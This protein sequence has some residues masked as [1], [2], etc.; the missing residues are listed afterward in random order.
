[1]SIRKNALLLELVGLAVVGALAGLLLGAV[2]GSGQM[3]VFVVMGVLG[4]P[5]L[6]KMACWTW[7]SSFFEGLFKLAAILGT[8]GLL[9]LVVLIDDLV[10]KHVVAPLYRGE[11]PLRLT[12]LKLDA[13]Q[14]SQNEPEMAAIP[15]AMISAV[16]PANATD[17][18]PPTTDDLRLHALL[19]QLASADWK[20]A[21]TAAIDLGELGDVRAAEPLIGCLSHD[22]PDV[23]WGAAAALAKLGDQLKGTEQA[24]SAASKLL[25]LLADPH[26]QLRASAADALG[27]LGATETLDRLIDALIDQEEHVVTSAAEALGRLGDQR[28]VSP[29]IACLKR[30][31]WAVRAFAAQAL[32]KLTGQALGEDAIAWE[33]WVAQRP[34]Q[35]KAEKDKGRDLRAALW[36]G[37]KAARL[38]RGQA[39]VAAGGEDALWGQVFFALLAPWGSPE[40]EAA[41]EAVRAS[42]EPAAEPLAAALAQSDAQYHAAEL[43]RSHGTF[44]DVRYHLERWMVQ[45]PDS[46]TAWAGLG[47]LYFVHSKF[48]PA[49]ACFERAQALGENSERVAEL[50][51]Q[52]S[53]S[54]YAP[55]LRSMPI[56]RIGMSAAMSERSRLDT[57][58]NF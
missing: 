11:R 46:A 35:T 38:A 18:T 20:T 52:L 9:P 21:K 2:D 57:L 24:V 55:H 36:Q 56:L 4:L 6:A 51:S 37:D 26:W 58:H 19:Q 47:N 23:R 1:M 12:F 54:A 22:N 40:R 45:H 16:T 25:E 44:D 15:A 5:L 27:M 41:L 49:L 28:A 7:H 42:G 39:L 17:R 50:I 13:P 53:L 48:A 43:T 32:E 33:R 10:L 8:F 3:A 14:I 31:H 29:L 30:G 34:S